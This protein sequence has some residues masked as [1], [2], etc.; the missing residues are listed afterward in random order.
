MRYRQRDVDLLWL[1]QPT[2]V[3]FSEPR[4]TIIYD[5]YARNY[6]RAYM[7]TPRR[8]IQKSGCTVSGPRNLVGDCMRQ[9]NVHRRT[10]TRAHTHIR[11]WIQ[12]LSIHRYI[13]MYISIY[14]YSPAF[15]GLIAVSV[16]FVASGHAAG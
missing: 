4:R 1:L 11:A 3:L 9:C 2:R 5:R 14:I 10:H 6:Y 16:Q 13:Y 8:C 12:V 7:H 15:V